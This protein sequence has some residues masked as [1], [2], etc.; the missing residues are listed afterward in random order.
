ME[1]RHNFAEFSFGLL[2]GLALGAVGGIILAPQ[3]GEKT[4]EQL[5]SRAEDIRVSTQDL[6]DNARSNLEQATGRLEGVFGLQEKSLRRK[7]DALR[8]E[9]E[10]YDLTGA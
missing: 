7:L 6:I 2:L 8:L 5:A 3:S 9:L 4:R 10:N 1:K